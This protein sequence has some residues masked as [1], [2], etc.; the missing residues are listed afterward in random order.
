MGRTSRTNPAPTTVVVG[1]PE[2]D[3]AVA[4][5]VQ[6]SLATSAPVVQATGSKTQVAFVKVDGSTVYGTQKQV[7]AWAKLRAASQARSA[8]LTPAQR[9]AS[10]AK[11]DD[12]LAG[13]A[14]RAAAKP[15][16]RELAAALRG[17]SLPANG[18]SWDKAK[19]ALAKG[20]TVAQAVKAA[21]KA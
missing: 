3:A 12:F 6:A 19:A 20:K 16:N 15:V 11:R 2:F 8:A 21:A 14:A 9:A 10:Q 4:A 7:N 13:R 17:A 1:S 5:A 18:P